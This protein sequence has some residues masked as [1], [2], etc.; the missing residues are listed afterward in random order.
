MSSL[1]GFSFF[2]EILPVQSK[3]LFA[4]QAPVPATFPDQAG[5]ILVVEYPSYKHHLFPLKLK[6]S[7]KYTLLKNLPVNLAV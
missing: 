4:Y 3:S 7:I 2:Q 6:L 1:S 5:V